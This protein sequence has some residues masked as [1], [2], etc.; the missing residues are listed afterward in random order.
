MVSVSRAVVFHR[1]MY[2]FTAAPGYLSRPI[3]NLHRLAPD[4]RGERT[5]AA[6]DR[7]RCLVRLPLRSSD[8]PG[9]TTLVVPGS[10]DR[11]DEEQLL[12]LLAGLMDVRVATLTSRASLALWLQPLEIGQKSACKQIGCADLLSGTA[13]QSY[14]WKT[15]YHAQSDNPEDQYFE[16]SCSTLTTS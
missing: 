5:A 15:A 11:I 4:P 10:Y 6:P 14:F 1:G 16:E 2:L 13:G 9:A 8:Q 12:G 7:A 3:I